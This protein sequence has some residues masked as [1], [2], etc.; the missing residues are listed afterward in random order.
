MMSNLSFDIAKDF[1]P[2]ALINEVAVI[3]VVHP[4]SA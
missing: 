4:R 2:V 3:L 1:A